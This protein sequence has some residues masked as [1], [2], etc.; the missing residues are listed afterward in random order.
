MSG[1][2]QRQ[3]LPQTIS[4]NAHSFGF[5]LSISMT[6][7]R[8]I[9]PVDDTRFVSVFP[10]FRLM[11]SA[12]S[13]LVYN[14]ILLYQRSVPLTKMELYFL[15]NAYY[16]YVW[17]CDYTMMFAQS[18]CLAYLIEAPTYI[19]NRHILKLFRFRA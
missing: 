3:T 8:Y 4:Q 5:N 6:Y 19:M 13:L 12:L 10:C 2:I 17:L 15:I 16:T 11:F 9:E 18:L 7:R 1:Y 14:L